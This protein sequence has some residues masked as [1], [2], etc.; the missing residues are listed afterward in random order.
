MKAL[1]NNKNH[2]FMA[3]VGFAWSIFVAIQAAKYSIVNEIHGD[4][5]FTFK[6]NFIIFMSGI[7]FLIPLIYSIF[8]IVKSFH[9]KSKRL[10]LLAYIN[11]ILFTLMFSWFMGAI[12]IG[13]GKSILNNGFFQFLKYS[14]IPPLAMIYVTSYVFYIYSKYKDDFANGVQK[15]LFL[16]HIDINENK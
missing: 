12:H 9:S 8:K 14:F 3:I 5:F 15:T 7:V 16:F 6:S 2:I 13:I 11:T 10:W 1:V 4:N